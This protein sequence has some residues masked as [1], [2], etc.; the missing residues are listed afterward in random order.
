MAMDKEMG[1]RMQREL[2]CCQIGMKLLPSILSVIPTLI[3]STSAK[4]EREKE[5]ESVS[6][7]LVFFGVAIYP[8]YPVMLCDE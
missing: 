5:K 1:M 3:R 4:T 8:L 7:A 2:W 6:M